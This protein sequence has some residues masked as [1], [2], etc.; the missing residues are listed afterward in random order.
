MTDRFESGTLSKPPVPGVSLKKIVDA[1]DMQFDDLRVYLNPENGEVVSI[2]DENRSV[3]E[4]DGDPEMLPAWQRQAIESLRSLDLDAL[5][6]LPDK[7]EIHEWDIVR[8]F[9]MSIATEAQREALLDAIHGSGAFRMFRR[10]LD[11]LRLRDAWFAYRATALK[12]IAR[13]WIEEHGFTC[14]ED[15]D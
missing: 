15:A 14:I 3:L 5:L 12:Q 10:E 9:A 6:P 7:F 4:G 1:L 8:R 2:S 11:R 13:E